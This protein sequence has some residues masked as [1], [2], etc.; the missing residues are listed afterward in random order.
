MLHSLF[1]GVE[2]PAAFEMHWGAVVALLL[3]FAI[4]IVIMIRVV[5]LKRSPGETMAWIL[6]VFVMPIFGP[7]LYLTFG[8]LRLGRRRAQRYADLTQPVKN[9]LAA[10]PERSLVEWSRLDGD[11]EQMAELCERNAGVPA[12]RGNSVELIDEWR[13]VF[14]QLLSD[15]DDAKS[16]CHLEFYIWNNGGVADQLSEALIR[17]EARGVVCRV[18][19]DAMGSHKFLRSKMCQ[20][21]R[22]AGVDVRDALPGGLL[23]LPFVRFD[24][25]MHRKIVVIDGKIGYTGSLNLVDPRYFKRDAGV[26]QWVDAMVRIQGP[27][28]EAL[29]IVFLGDW[30]IETSTPLEELQQSGD[31][32]PQPRR[33]ESPVQVIPAGP[34]LPGR[35]VE[36]VLMTAVYAARRELIMTTPYFVPSEALTFALISAVQRGVKVILV[37]PK[38]VD[39]KLVKYAS[40]AFKGELLEAGV[41][42]ALFHDGLLHTKSVTVDESYSL[43]GSVNLDPR[44]FRLNFE[45]L[46]A[47]YDSEFTGRL[48]QLQQHYIDRSEL[49]DL[50]TYRHRPRTQ[51]L[52]ENFARLMG[53]LL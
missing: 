33:G 22:A 50:E 28:V 32:D 36:H 13:H 47:I 15:I 27:A 26:G 21:M 34:D 10:I 51:Q 45:I 9:W 20:R 41:K 6:V 49:M 5:M 30:Y 29:Q 4:Q 14:D 17:A 12:M 43:F 2:D 37:V 7:L 39:S 46:L 31:A 24:L 48:R 18:L 25:R 1:S 8:E 19:V 42:I 35:A 3:H 44:S 38:R 52:A 53:P 23:R 40:G 11:F 16:T